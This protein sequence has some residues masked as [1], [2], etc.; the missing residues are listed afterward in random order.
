MIISSYTII[1]QPKIVH[2]TCLF[3]T[4][5][6]FDSEEYKKFRKWDKKLTA[7]NKACMLPNLQPRD[8]IEKLPK[9]GNT[10]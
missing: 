8:S 6:L 2:P 4:A 5:Q 1:F 9:I 3:H 10:I 7:Q